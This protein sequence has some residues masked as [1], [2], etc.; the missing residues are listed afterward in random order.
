MN[1]GGT[2]LTNMHGVYGNILRV[3]AERLKLQRESDMLAM[4]L[5]EMGEEDADADI[6]ERT[7]LQDIEAQ[8]RE[9]LRCL[10][11]YAMS[12][13]GRSCVKDDTRSTSELPTQNE[14]LTSGA[15]K[16]ST[17][18]ALC[19]LIEQYRHKQ[20]GMTR[21]TE[22]ELRASCE[23]AWQAHGSQMHLNAESRELDAREADVRNILSADAVAS[24][25][26]LLGEMTLEVNQDIDTVLLE[27]GSTLFL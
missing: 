16:D 25:I 27:Y 2:V 10:I 8:E 19:D 15:A 22:K 5:E 12:G 6:D 24:E 13:S 9:L 23:A 7:V 17:D 11:Q 14:G 1:A 26:D 4:A 21:D 20:E 18:D 3:R